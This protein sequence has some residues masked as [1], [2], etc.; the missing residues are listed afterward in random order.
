MSGPTHVVAVVC[1]SQE[2]ADEALA[3]AETLKPADAVLV[4]RTPDGRI[5]LHQTRQ[6]S[7]GEGAITGGTVGL[8]AGLLFGVPVG[9]SLAGLLGGGIFGAR[10]TGIKDARLREL[11]E[12]LEVG[13]A[14][15]C[16]LVADDARAATCEALGAY[17]AVETVE[18]APAP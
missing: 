13:E 4:R 6:K 17:G 2:Q 9:V 10:D 16:V 12:R 1:A 11:G 15:V 14:M 18:A 3:A 5:D 8:L 7:V